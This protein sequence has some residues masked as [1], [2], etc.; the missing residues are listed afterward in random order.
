MA[1]ASSRPHYN[2]I[3]AVLLLGI[4]A[5]SLL[6][7]LV[8]PVLALLIP[9][10]HTTQDTATWLMTGYLLSA[11]VATPIV[12]RVGDKIGKAR[13]L[14]VVLC[15]LTIGCLIAAL[16]DSVGVLIVARVIQGVGGGVL[17]LAF[18]I[19][20]DEFPHA[21]LHSAVGAAAAL[22]AVGAGL[23]LVV[24]GPIVDH[25]NY[26]WLFWIPMIMT[27]VAAA[28]TN[29]LVPESPVRSQE[30]INW[31]AAL[32]LSGWLVAAL[33][34]VSKGPRWGWGSHQTLGC[35]ALAALCLVLWVWA[36]TSSAT[37]LI[38]MRTMRIPAVWT[39]NLVA[40][41]A[42]A[43]MY[44]TMTFLPQLIQTPKAIAGYGLS[45]TMSQS[46]IYMLPITVAI[47]VM[48]LVTGPLA[49]RIGAKAVVIT[50]AVIMVVP[51]VSLALGH[52]RGW[53]IYIAVSALGI[54]LGLVF[55]SMAAIVVGAVPPAQTGAATGINANIRTVG[56]AVGSALSGS[57]LTATVAA[58][59][60]LPTDA[61][62]T[63]VFWFLAAVAVT[64]VLASLL[65]PTIHPRGMSVE[66]A[67]LEAQQSVSVSD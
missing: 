32:L 33:L 57:I 19:I 7:S 42:G 64:A 31:T 60:H 25:L 52:A 16:T 9:A 1:R 14:V 24:A 20:R 43:S 67:E 51:F 35:F 47:F 2:V 5:F 45:A 15:V 62:Y 12:G 54:G 18:G 36:E 55:S 3:F 10:L 23:G 58:G 37:S 34:A 29:L 56:G 48:G 28:A 40:L 11:S 53:Q 27:A 66:A 26:H 4:T 44:A 41:L 22:G 63:R 61:G 21:K 8:V 13:T 50:G 59:H 30:G 39:T 49:A 65:I 38:D 46:G 6:Q 17:P